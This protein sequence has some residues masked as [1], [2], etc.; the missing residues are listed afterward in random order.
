VSFSTATLLPCN[1]R[2]FLLEK[3]AKGII[4]TWEDSNLAAVKKYVDMKRRNS[5]NQEKKKQ[6]I[7]R[8]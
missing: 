4:G 2:G 3:T 6:R 8:G 7:T 5:F 1:G